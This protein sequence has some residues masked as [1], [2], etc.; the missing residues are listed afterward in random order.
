MKPESAN[1]QVLCRLRKMRN[2]NALVNEATAAPM[3]SV[4]K[5]IGKAQHTSVLVLANNVSQLIPASL[6][7]TL[8]ALPPALLGAWALSNF[9]L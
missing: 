7:N 3:P 8:R 9:I 2:G 5:M 1:T 6:R 4:T